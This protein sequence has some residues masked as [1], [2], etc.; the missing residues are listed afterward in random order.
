MCHIL[1]MPFCFCTIAANVLLPASSNSI[2]LTNIHLVSNFINYFTNPTKFSS[3]FTSQSLPHAPNL[4]W[5][6]PQLSIPSCVYPYWSYLLSSA[7]EIIS[8]SVTPNLPR[9]RVYVSFDFKRREPNILQSR[10]S[11]SAELMKKE[12]YTHYSQKG[13]KKTIWAQF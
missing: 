3:R 1:F 12:W 2:S 10:C 13:N 8:K 9:G 11:I 5:M 4:I 7:E 6:P